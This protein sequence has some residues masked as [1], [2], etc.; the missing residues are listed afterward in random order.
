MPINN[1]QI[2]RPLS[3]CGRH[4]WVTNFKASTFNLNIQFKRH[5]FRRRWSPTS[6]LLQLLRLLSTF[7]AH[8]LLPLK[9]LYQMCATSLPFKFIHSQFLW[10][11]H[12]V[13]AVPKPFLPVL[14]SLRNHFTAGSTFLPSGKVIPARG[15]T[16]L[17][18]ACKKYFPS[19]LSIRHW[20]A[21]KSS[22]AI[23]INNTPMFANTSVY[24]CPLLSS[25]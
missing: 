21:T 20:Y 16:I 14:L 7:N 6:S 19:I 10:L 25:D 15:L 4:A 13:F 3:L 23:A 12:R 18:N 2:F 5:L 24:W 1:C 11:S 22:T 8:K 9:S 17:Q